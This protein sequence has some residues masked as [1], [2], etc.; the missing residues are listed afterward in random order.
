MNNKKIVDNIR[1]LCET[2]QISVSQLEREL[3]M[4]PGLISRWNKNLPTLD[5]IY[6]IASYFS[7][8]METIVGNASENENGTKSRN[9]NRLL[10]VLYRQSINAEVEW[11]VLNPVV[12]LPILND[13]I[14][15]Y[16]ITSNQ[17]DVFYCPINEGYFF[18][19][20]DYTSNTEC[21]LRLY[22]L[23]DS[24]SIPELRCTDTEKLTQLYTYLKKRLSKK[25]NSIKTD[26]FI[27][28]FI[29]SYSATE[30]IALL[31]P[32]DSKSVVNQ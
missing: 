7:V 13:N 23:P 27:N 19:V 28:E 30:N 32:S 26:N 8:P 24:N 11:D 3:F 9:I 5:R 1:L 22:V 15:S 25:L 14:L 12:P 4:S 10:S 21:E 16:L 18:F 20:M 31:S 17:Q 2:N 6:D 29:T